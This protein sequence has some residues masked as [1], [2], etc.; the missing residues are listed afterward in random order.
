MDLGAFSISLAPCLIRKWDPVLLN[1]C[2]LPGTANTSLPCSNAS[3][4]VMREPLCFVAS[5]TTTPLL[6]PLMIRF[7]MGKFLGSGGLPI[8]NSVITTPFSVI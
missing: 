1:E 4:A 5:T 8:G 2:M 3:E 7:L 6:K